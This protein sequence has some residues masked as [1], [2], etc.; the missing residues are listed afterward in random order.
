MDNIS[1]L[2]EDY[3]NYMETIKGVSA[4]TTNEYFLD[5]S[6][7]DHLQYIEECEHAFLS[8]VYSYYNIIKVENGF[9]NI[10]W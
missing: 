9:N 1:L 2:L 4:N 7:E 6:R 10:E 3:L 8:L 5:L